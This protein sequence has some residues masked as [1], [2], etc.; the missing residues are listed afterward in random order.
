MLSSSDVSIIIPE[1]KISD[2]DPGSGLVASRTNLELDSLFEPVGS[3]CLS[4]RITGRAS[5]SKD[6]VDSALSF[7]RVQLERGERIR[8]YGPRLKH[9]I[10]G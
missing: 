8:C 7:M 4:T 9:S 3:K 6:S 1:V 10:L 5:R 2:G